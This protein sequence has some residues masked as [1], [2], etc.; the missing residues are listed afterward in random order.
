MSVIGLIGTAL[1][2]ALVVAP[3]L[4]LLYPIAFLQSAVTGFAWAS[5]PAIAAN[6]VPEGE[7]GQLAGVNGAVGGLMA[8]IGPLCAG[9]AY[10]HVAA[11]APFLLG[12]ALLV[13]AGMVL[14]GA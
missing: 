3:S 8:M 5:L 13:L 2:A 4:W 11:W 10:D 14:T 7:Q 6:R 12:A 9:A 1:G